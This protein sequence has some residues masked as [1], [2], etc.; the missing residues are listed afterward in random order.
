MYE[1]TDDLV[2]P[3]P[4]YANEYGVLAVGGD[5]SS[6]RLALAYRY[7][8]FPWFE[9]GEPIVWWSPSERFV[10]FPEELK[11]SKSMRQVLRSNR[12][13]ITRN[14]AFEQVITLCKN[15]KRKGQQGTW[16]TDEMQKSYID[17]HKKGFAESIEVWKNGTLVGGLYGVIVGNVFCGESMFSKVPN[18]SKLAFIHLVKKGGYT[19]IDCQVHTKHLESLGARHIERGLFLEYLGVSAKV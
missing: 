13:Q 5:L 19:L 16:I 17:F 2:F 8:I 4:N 3:H 10:L 1:L 14:N 6:E 12:F 11:V 15:I 9:E 18:T 7:G